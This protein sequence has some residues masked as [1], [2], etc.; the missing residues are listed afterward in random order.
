MDKC[1]ENTRNPLKMQDPANE[2]A[3]EVEEADQC[4]ARYLFAQALR[5]VAHRPVWNR[6]CFFAPNPCF[7]IKGGRKDYPNSII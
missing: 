2:G 3:C 4:R 1:Q 5:L 7:P 6:L